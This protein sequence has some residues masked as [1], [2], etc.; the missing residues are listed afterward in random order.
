MARE[1]ISDHRKIVEREEVKGWQ[2]DY[3]REFNDGEMPQRIEVAGKVVGDHSK[4]FSANHSLI[5]NTFSINW[6]LPAGSVPD[7]EVSNAVFATLQEI[8]Q[9]HEPVEVAGE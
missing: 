8:K 6:G 1:I 3:T 2:I 5:D 9:G 4:Y 7:N